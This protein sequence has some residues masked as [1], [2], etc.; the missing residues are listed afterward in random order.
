VGIGGRRN[1]GEMWEKFRKRIMS[2]CGTSIKELTREVAFVGA[3]SFLTG[4]RREVLGGSGRKVNRV[5]GTERGT[6]LERGGGGWGTCRMGGC[7]R[8]RGKLRSKGLCAL[9]LGSGVGG[10]SRGVAEVE[11]DSPGVGKGARW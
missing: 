8:S 4:G 2:G 10:Q 9:G 1:K 3:G 11:G 7:G 5:P 6:G